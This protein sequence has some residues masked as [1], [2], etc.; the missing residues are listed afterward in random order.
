MRAADVEA[1]AEIQA[2]TA[3]IKREVQPDLV[4]IVL[5]G[6]CVYFP[7]MTANVSPAPTVLSVHGSWP[8]V[9]FFAPVGLLRR[10]LAVSDRFT[11]CS[12]SALADLLAI[13]ESIAARAETILNGLDP[14][15]FEPSPLPFDPP[16]RAARSA[17]L[18]ESTRFRFASE[19]AVAKVI[20]GDAI[21]ID[22]VTGRYY[23]LEGTAEVAWSLL[24][25]SLTIGEVAEALRAR[26]ETGEADVVADVSR[27]AQELVDE[28][29]IVEAPDAPGSAADATEEPAGDY[30][31]PTLTVFRD[32]EDL[33][34]FDPPLPVADVNVWTAKP[35]TP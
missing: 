28:S 29:L 22:T 2:E 8:P 30:S 25:S 32:M 3:A 1:I 20:D 9:Q 18:P 23:S 7:V 6:A 12:D 14:P 33:L 35:D 26:Y 4:H 31:A 27:L 15:P 10:A 21:V 16:V 19:R 34:A 5:T 17:M 13:D 24:T 11:A